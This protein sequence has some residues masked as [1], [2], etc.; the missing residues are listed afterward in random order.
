M[1]EVAY[2]PPPT[3]GGGGGTIQPPVETVDGVRTDFTFNQSPPT[4]AVVFINGEA[5]LPSALSFSGASLSLPF[6]PT[7]LFGYW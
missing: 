5:Y 6:A 2:D 7:A 3:G 1:P 4:N